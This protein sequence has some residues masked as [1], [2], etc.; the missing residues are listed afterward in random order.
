MWRHRWRRPPPTRRRCRRAAARAAAG[1]GRPAPARVPLLLRASRAAWTMTWRSLSSGLLAVGAA[2][3]AALPL[4]PKMSLTLRR[5]Q[6]MRTAAGTPATLQRT[7]CA[8]A[9]AEPLRRPPSSARQTMPSTRRL[10]QA[11]RLPPW[12]PLPPPS[13]PHPWRPWQRLRSPQHRA[14]A[15]PPRQPARPRRRAGGASLWW[16]R[17]HPRVGRGAAGLAVP[18]LVYCW[19]PPQTC[20]HRRFPTCISLPALPARW[21]RLCACPHL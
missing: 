9:R 7:R 4:S 17:Q 3:A 21:P 2:V 19:A 11:R 18:A 6:G 1:A 5:R 15:R 20:M 8:S 13:W 12:W 14:A 10:P 16:R